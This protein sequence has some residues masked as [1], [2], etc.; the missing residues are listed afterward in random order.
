MVLSTV[1][2]AGC[3]LPEKFTASL[4]VASD[5]SYAYRYEGL[6]AFI[7]AIMKM[8]Q[9]GM[10]LSAKDDSDLQAEAVKMGRSPDFRKA[11]YVGRG[12]YELA[13][14]G[15]RKAGQPVNV[16]D[17]LRVFSEKDGT[18][19]IVGA[20]LKAQDKA[21]LEKLNL[22]IDGTLEV[23]IPKNAEVISTNA[24]SSPSFFGM[25]GT[26]SWKIG[27]L[28]QRPLMRIRLR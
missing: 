20:E 28:E 4:K 7:P 8:S 12:R 23:S 14:A 27:S 19:N 13:L 6:T 11:S 22:K 18:I 1:V 21:Q 24:T 5:G 2:L 17:A 25:V 16:L 26:Y 9:G 10:K 3:Y 15:E